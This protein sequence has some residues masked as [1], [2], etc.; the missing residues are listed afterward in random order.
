MK[1]LILATILSFIFTIGCNTAMAYDDRNTITD[2]GTNLTFHCQGNPCRLASFKQGETI[3]TMTEYNGDIVIQKSSLTDGIYDFGWS[4]YIS[5]YVEMTW[6]DYL[7]WQQS[8]LNNYGNI[9]EDIIISN[10]PPEPTVNNFNSLFEFCSETENWVTTKLYKGSNAQG[11][12]KD[13][14]YAPCSSG[15]TGSLGYLND[16]DGLS[17]LGINFTLEL[18]DYFFTIEEMQG[19]SSTLKTGRKIEMLYSVSDVNNNEPV[20][21][22]ETITNLVTISGTCTDG[23]LNQDETSTD[24]GGV[25]SIATTDSLIKINTPS[26]GGTTPETIIDFSGEYYYDESIWTSF[27][28]FN[29][30]ILQL[31]NTETLEQ[32]EIYLEYLTTGE[33]VEWETTYELPTNTQWK[34]KAFLRVGITKMGLISNEVIFNVVVPRIINLNQYT[35]EECD[36]TDI[37]CNFKNG[38]NWGVDKLK[39]LAKDTTQTLYE[40]IPNTLKNLEFFPFSLFSEMQQAMEQG[41]AEASETD[42]TGNSQYQISMNVL[43]TQMKIFDMSNTQALMGGTATNILKGILSMI[44]WL[45]FFSHVYYGIMKEAERLSQGGK[46]T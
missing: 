46:T 36:M 10:T 12:Y 30:V 33:L 37:G 39:T 19:N 41:V 11:V 17:I 31:T 38:W 15:S 32:H 14:S 35:P 27:G 24:F 26:N 4:G 9:A 20:Y 16:T 40:N 43:G 13:G 34:A 21:T 18:G 25:C 2:N 1:K 22:S 6:A 3:G 8:N 42:T 29:G 45:M 28:T 7:A 23:I 5:T 44:L